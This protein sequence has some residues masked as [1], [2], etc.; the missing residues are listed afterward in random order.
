M[1]LAKGGGS[2]SS[3]LGRRLPRALANS[4]PHTMLTPGLPSL[5]RSS[6]CLSGPC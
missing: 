6:R 5:R 3:S 4:S 1:N 2:S